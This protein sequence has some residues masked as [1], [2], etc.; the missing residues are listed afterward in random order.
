MARKKLRFGAKRWRED[1]SNPAS[2]AGQKV[3]NDSSWGRQQKGDA[4][5]W[6]LSHL[7]ESGTSRSQPE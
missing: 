3:G 6:R 7:V 2:R 1:A 5:P 4:T